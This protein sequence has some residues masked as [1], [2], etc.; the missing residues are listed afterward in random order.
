MYDVQVMNGAVVA[1]RWQVASPSVIYSAADQLSD[2]GSAPASLTLT[3][4]QRSALVGPGKVAE[5]TVVV[6]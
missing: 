6:Q 3:I 5:V 2:F 4:T 1:R